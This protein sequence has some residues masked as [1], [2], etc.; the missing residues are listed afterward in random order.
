MGRCRMSKNKGNN[1]NANGNVILFQTIT[2]K[3]KI[4][5]SGA[6]REARRKG[7]YKCLSTR[8]EFDMAW[9]HKVNALEVDRCVLNGKS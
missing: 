3:K 2:P 1:K 7:D 5:E 9:H 8:D 4:G 6:G